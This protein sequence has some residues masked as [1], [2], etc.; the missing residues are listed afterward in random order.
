MFSKYVAH[1]NTKHRKTIRSSADGGKITISNLFH[2]FF[3]I[4][5]CSFFFVLVTARWSGDEFSFDQVLD[6]RS[7]TFHEPQAVKPPSHSFRPLLF[8]K[9]KKPFVK[10]HNKPR[11]YTHSIASSFSFFLFLSFLSKTIYYYLLHVV[12]CLS[13]AGDRKVFNSASFLSLSVSFAPNTNE[14]NRT[15]IESRLI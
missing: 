8:W 15:K 12:E 4:F 3:P 14:T 2:F 6:A 10:R 11:A 1:N 13:S 7:I 5:C 9:N